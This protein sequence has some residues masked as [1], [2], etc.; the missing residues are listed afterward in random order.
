MFAGI[1]T[2]T[3]TRD[4]EITD[5]LLQQYESYEIVRYFDNIRPGGN[6]G[7][8]V[9]TFSTRY[10]DRYAEQLWD[11]L[12]A[13]APEITLF[14]W[15]G[16][17]DPHAIE[18]GERPWK[19]QKTSFDWNAAMSSTQDAGWGR[20]AGAALESVDSALGILGRPT[21]IASYKPYQSSS[22]E[23]FL[24]NYLG[25]IGLPIEMTPS[26]PAQ[27]HTVLLTENAKAD[28]KIVAKMKASLRAG[29]NVVITSGLLRALQGRGIEDIVEWNVTGQFAA[30]H[31]FLNGYGAGN[32]TSLNDPGAP[33]PA[34]LFPEIHF[35]TNDSW[36]IIRGVA[37]AKGYPILL[38]NHYSNGIIY[39]LAI[40]ENVGD[41]YSLPTGVLVQIR[42]YL[43]EGSPVRIDAPSRVSLFTY[44]NGTF[45][46]ESFRDTNTPVTISLDGGGRALADALTKETLAPSPAPEPTGRRGQP[47]L[48]T[49]FAVD[50]PPHSWRAFRIAN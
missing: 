23:D 14:S 39:V 1:Y 2:G 25:N 18:P 37:G 7:G 11:T 5:Q 21:G 45:V 12:F 50:I 27:A 35:Y 30:V 13:K 10:A 22:G 48:R 28:P 20:V 4:P 8:W 43:Q 29:N 3:E 46:L 36:P 38:M 6:G 26:Y 34:I 33:D 17:A 15:G 41:I 24:Q 42:T 47:S 16:L 44:D 49:G 40:P 31:D 9:D 32:G 19:D